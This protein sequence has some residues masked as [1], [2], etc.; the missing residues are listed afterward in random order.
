MWQVDN[1]NQEDDDKQQ[2]LPLESDGDCDN[3][4]CPS[5]DQKMKYIGNAK[6]QIFPKVVVCMMW[7]YGGSRSVQ[8]TPTL[9]GG[10]FGPGNV[11]ANHIRHFEDIVL[12]L[13]LMGS[14]RPDA[15]S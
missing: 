15:H 7:Q 9:S 5:K 11:R 13:H 2:V 1:H 3:F 8:D 10:N 12:I 14:G 6:I 4:P